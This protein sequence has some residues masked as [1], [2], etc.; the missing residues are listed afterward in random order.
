MTN[1]IQTDQTR[2]ICPE[3]PSLTEAICEKDRECQ[4]R[5]FS[6]RINGLW[7]GKCLLP[8]EAHVFNGTMN[9]TKRTTGL[10]EYAG[11]LKINFSIRG[12]L[13]GRFSSDYISSALYTR[14]I[15]DMSRS[16]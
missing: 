2:S 14:T 16:S 12:K 3:S 6:P 5:P 13:T 1:F 15:D 8:P 10:C 7:T 11:K 4:N 9:I